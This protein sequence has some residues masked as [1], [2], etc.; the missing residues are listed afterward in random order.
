VADVIRTCANCGNTQATGDFCEKCGSRMPAATAAEGAAAAYSAAYQAP[1][2]PGAYQP[3]AYQSGTYQPGTPPPYAYGVQPQYGY[4][5]EP[6]SWNKLFDLSFQGF[7]TPPVLRVLFFILL[8]LIGLF[9][10][11]SI[12]YGALMGA[13]FGVLYIFI[14]LITAVLWFF[15]T[16]LLLELIATA[17][18]VRDR[19]E[20]D[21][22]T[23]S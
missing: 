2:S 20:K 22:G 4:Q 21:A 14:A 11:L 5:K 18:R 8:G 9:L 12:V 16:R 6:S 10:I 23:K 19:A 17:Q 15:W 13:R 1:P 7:A 3:G